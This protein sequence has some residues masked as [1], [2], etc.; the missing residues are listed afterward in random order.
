[1]EWTVRRATIADADRL[2]LI[3]S[4]TFLETFAGLL[5]GDAIVDHCA[6]EHSSS[7]YRRYLGEG[8]EAWLVETRSG[9]APVGFSLLGGTD[10]PGSTSDGSDIELKRIYTLSRFHGGGIGS[11]LMRQAV[12]LAE[13][14]GC[15]RLLLGVYAGNGRARAFYT[16]SGFAQIADRRFGVG[17]REYDD[18]VLARQLDGDRPTS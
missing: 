15:R 11:A 4:A 13:H 7:A 1:M 18:V 16:K 5:D 6:R 10:L 3:G 2:A 8:A 9:M 12:D 17:D 14:K